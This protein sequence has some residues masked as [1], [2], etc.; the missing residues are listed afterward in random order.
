MKRLV[1]IL[2]LS[3]IL[4]L[5]LTAI[6]S[7]QGGTEPGTSGAAAGGVAQL[8]AP[9]LAAATAIERVI[10]MVFSFGEGMWLR[11][12]QVPEHV[13]SYVAWARQQVK[14]ARDDLLNGTA[15]EAPGAG[16]LEDKL[17]DAQK[18]MEAI[19]KTDP[20]ISIKRVISLVAGIGLGLAVAL[21][22]KLRM[23]D[24]LGVHLGD[25]PF[26][27]TM[28]MI[29]TGLVIGTGSAPV[30]S[31]IGILQK[32]KDAIDEAR[33]LAAGKANETQLE[34]IKLLKLQ[35]SETQVRGLAA[36]EAGGEPP[37][38]SPSRVELERTL[39][40]LLRR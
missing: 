30:H 39:D 22:T 13:E 11:V 17:K 25:T 28:D 31:L 15:T 38:P 14:K 23:F 2:L 12:A 4:S 33:A 3:I 7:A 24:L 29:V 36:D 16:A 5:A 1:R 18:R 34:I 27:A 20:Y 35:E 21:L 19:L 37:S 26:L 32:S 8:L 40:G 9:L 10:E 6:V